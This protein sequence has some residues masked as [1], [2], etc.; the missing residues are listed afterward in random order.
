MSDI[1]VLSPQDFDA[2]T[3]VFAH[4]YPGL[5]SDT[6]EDKERA[7]QRMLETHREEPTV[8]FYGL[9]RAGRL[10]GGMRFHDF[11][12]SFLQT[13]IAAGGVGAVAVDLLHKKEHVAKEM[14]LYFLR[15]YRERGA[16]LVLLYPFRPDFY[17]KMG[18]GYGPKVN[19]YCIKPDALLRGPSK[20][21]VRSLDQGDKQALLDC[22][23]RF[24]RR[25]HGMIAKSAYEVKRLMENPRNQIVGYEQ[26]GKLL[27]YLVFTFERGENFILNDIHI[28]EFVYENPQALSELL[29]LLHTQADQI[30]HI[31]L[32]TQDESFHHLLLD[33]RISPP[34]II[35]PVYHQSNLQGTGLMYRVV[36]TAAVFDLLRERDFGGQTCRLK[37]TVEDSFLPENAGSTRLC[38]EDGHLRVVD[39]GPHDVETRLDI[40]EFSSMLVGAVN[41][42][43]LY[44]YGLADLTDPEY[45]GTVDKLFAV[46]TKPVCT[47]HF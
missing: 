37:L 9:F 22:Y 18:F 35:S 10:L 45:V 8:T 39:D 14:M 33:P 1:R 21:H 34:A 32:Q 28:H 11:A 25:T 46:E 23:H 24:M 41:F 16:P 12:M 47:T 40:A 19:H 44:S 20:A 3:D 15:H 31:I 13:E 5:V 42:R 26:D 17:K 27:G 2:F 6:E 43:K 29:T 30:R 36:D 7:K 4:A 38:F